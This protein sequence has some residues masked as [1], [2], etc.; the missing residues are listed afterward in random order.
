[1]ENFT[2]EPVFSGN[3]EGREHRVEQAYYLAMGYLSAKDGYPNNGSNAVIPGLIRAHDHKGILS[4][5]WTHRPSTIQVEAFGNAWV[6]LDGTP[7]VQHIL[8]HRRVY[9]TYGISMCA[10]LSNL[11]DA[12]T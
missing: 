3:G 12:M 11:D 7:T 8:V 4:C 10:Y 9:G 1:M 6:L 2:Q 5:F